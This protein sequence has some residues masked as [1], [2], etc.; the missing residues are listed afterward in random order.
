[1][2]H[3]APG[4]EHGHR[5]RD[6][7]RGAGAGPVHADRGLRA[8]VP[9]LRREAPPAVRREMTMDAASRNDAPAP[10]A[11]ATVSEALQWPF[12]D[13]DHRE[14]HVR[15]EAWLASACDALPAPL[16]PHATQAQL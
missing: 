16:S 6:R 5:H 8:R 12:F 11:A 1:Q 13:D 7:V 10:E 9:R 15:L 14:L 2:D 4:M 3:A